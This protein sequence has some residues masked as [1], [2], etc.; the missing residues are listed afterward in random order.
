MATTSTTSEEREAPRKPAVATQKLA[1]QL[2]PFDLTANTPAEAMREK[3]ARIRF[4]VDEAMWITG[5]VPHIE[6]GAGEELPGALLHLAMVANRTEENPLCTAEHT[7]NPL[8]AATGS[9]KEI[10]LPE[11]YGYA[12]VP[13][14]VLEATVTLQN[15]TDQDYREVYFT[16][17]IEGQP[18]ASTQMV[19]DVM[20]LLL[21]T[22]PCKHAPLAVEPGAY[23]KKTERFTVPEGGTVVAA[24]GLLQAYG[25][26]I[27]L[28]KES[29][30]APFWKA[31]TSIDDTYQITGLASYHNAEGVPINAGDRMVLSVAYQNFSDQ[32]FN[33]ATAAA[34]VYVARSHEQ[35][36]QSTAKPY[37]KKAADAAT[38]VQA[39]LLQ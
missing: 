39:A 14:D 29:E 20:P 28:A 23:V 16:F 37:S 24:Y 6:N 4:A 13:E 30:P 34:I 3:P 25:V 19:K 12:V 5:F 27:A 33:D 32:W 22:D 15:P 7:G 18:M 38:A 36:T 35:R 1:Y 11:G 2:G 8:M 9:L 31:A 21:D 26:E 10:Q 17:T